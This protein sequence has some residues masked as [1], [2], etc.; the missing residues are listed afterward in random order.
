MPDSATIWT[1]GNP[2]IEYDTFTISHSAFDPVRI[3]ASRGDE[4]NITILGNEY[5]PC[6]IELEY[7]KIDG[8]SA[9][10][11][12]FSMARPVVGDQVL[13]LIRSIPPHMRISE[14]VRVTMSHWTSLDLSEPMYSY[15]LDVANDGVSISVDTVTVKCEKINI[16]TRSVARIYDIEEWTGLELS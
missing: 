1:T 16:M 6:Y 12:S 11:A 4:F 15:T 5:Q 2:A 10:E 3:Y 13:R 7:P 8:E 9:P 14:P